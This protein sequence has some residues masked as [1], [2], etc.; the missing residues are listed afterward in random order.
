VRTRS[1]PRIMAGLRNLA[2]GALR[3]AGSA[4][5]TEAT[6]WAS[7]RA[8]RP[9]P[10]S[11]SQ[12]DLETAVG[13]G[14]P[15]RPGLGP[16]QMGLFDTSSDHEIDQPVDP[17]PRRPLS[18]GPY[19]V[20]YSRQTNAEGCRVAGTVISHRGQRIGQQFDQLWR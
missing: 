20:N 2:I 9:S 4:D 12:H 3:L 6:R 17:I 5:I 18:Y 15:A 7:R 14:L 16:V 11:D 8:D 19:L 1:G 13:P 10:L